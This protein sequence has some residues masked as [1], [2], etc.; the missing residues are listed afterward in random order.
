ML[1]KVFFN[2]FFTTFHFP[3][4]SELVKRENSD[5]IAEVLPAGKRATPF[6]KP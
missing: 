6:K 1:F 5:T 3:L 2:S 4:R